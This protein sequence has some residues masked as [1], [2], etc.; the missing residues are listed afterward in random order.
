VPSSWRVLSVAAYVVNVPKAL[1]VKAQKVRN[2]NRIAMKGNGESERRGNET[3]RNQISPGRHIIH[4][5]QRKSN[6]KL[7]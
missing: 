1:P 5:G 3:K 7:S 2:G 4:F 6:E